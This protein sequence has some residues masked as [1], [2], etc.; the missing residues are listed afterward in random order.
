M[1]KNAQPNGGCPNAFDLVRNTLRGAQEQPF[2]VTP[3]ACAC[4]S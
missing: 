2:K 3:F 4:S 1:N